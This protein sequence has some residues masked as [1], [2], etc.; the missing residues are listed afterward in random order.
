MPLLI[1]AGT[2]EGFLTLSAMPVAAKLSI[3]PLTVILLSAYR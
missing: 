1:I 2:I 3:A